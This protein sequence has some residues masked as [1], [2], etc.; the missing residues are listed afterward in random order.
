MLRWFSC[1]IYIQ[2]FTL[3]RLFSMAIEYPIFL[4]PSRQRTHIF[5][6]SIH[7]PNWTTRYVTH[8]ALSVYIKCRDIELSNKYFR[9]PQ[10]KHFILRKLDALLIRYSILC[11]ISWISKPASYVFLLCFCWETKRSF[12]CLWGAVRHECI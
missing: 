9:V 1:Q 11:A 2:L 8:S 7:V 5:L 6:F 12:R 3:N 4:Q 10:I